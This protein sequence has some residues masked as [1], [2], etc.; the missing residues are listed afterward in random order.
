MDLT[1]RGFLIG[2]TAGVG[3]SAARRILGR[4]SLARPTLHLIPRAAWGAAPPGPGLVP[5]TIDRAT[6]HHTGVVLADNRRAPTRLLEWDALH[7]H[8]RGWADLAYHFVVDRNGH[9]YEGRDPAYRGDTATSYDPAGRLLV[10][11]EGSFSE[12]SPTRRQLDALVGI[13]TWAAASYGF[14]PTAIDGHRDLAATDC[15]GDTLYAAIADG[16]LPR[17]VATVDAPHLRRLSLHDGHM[18]LAA[19]ADGT[20]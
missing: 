17:R 4:S 15:P 8:E 12:Q 5:H 1:R 3:A 2:L 9:L 18:L 13:L 10:A 14:T 11:C 6:I 7:R 20:I 16:T 19:I